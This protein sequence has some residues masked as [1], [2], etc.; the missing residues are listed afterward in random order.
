MGC[1]DC[2]RKLKGEFNNESLSDRRKYTNPECY[3]KAEQINCILPI[4]LQQHP[5]NWLW[6][7][8]KHY[9]I[10][11]ETVEETYVKIYATRIL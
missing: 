5:V 1:K 6:M 7:K 9:E 2:L 11:Y 10:T 8:C 4:S 3:F